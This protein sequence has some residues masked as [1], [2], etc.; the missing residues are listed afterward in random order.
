MCNQNS[1]TIN[2]KLE[3][4]KKLFDDAMNKAIKAVNDAQYELLSIRSE[5]VRPLTREEILERDEENL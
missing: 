4:A 1:P 3:E 5:L 2:E